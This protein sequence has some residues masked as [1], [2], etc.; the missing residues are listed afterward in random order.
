MEVQVTN[1]GGL[2]RQMTVR[3][4]AERVA[5]ALDERLKSLAG[6][7]RIAGFRPGKA[8]L[9][10]VQ[11]QYGESARLDVINDLVRGSYP[12]ALG[13]AGVHP[14]SAPSFEV[15]AEKAG[16]GLEYVARF[17]VYP[18]IKLNPLTGLKVTRPAVAVT[19]ADVEKLVDNLRRARRTFQ[20]VERAA[21]SGD[22]V[23][24]DFL[25]KLKGEPFEGG[26]GDGVEIEL[27]AKRFLPDL[28]N[29]I[30]GHK[31]GESFTV[32]VTFPDD[33][34]AEHLRGQTAQFDVTLKEVRETRLPELDAEFL[35]THGVEEGAGVD[36]L[37]AKC[38]SALDSER[39]KAVRGRLKAQ[40]M[41]QLLALNPIDV[42]PSVVAQEIGRLRNETAARFNAAK[43]GD[44]QKAKMFPDEVLAPMAQRR[45]ALGLLVAEVIKAKSIEPD[46]ARLEKQL[47][48]L[49]GD[50]EKPEQVKQFYRSRPDLMQGL[51]AMVLEEQ[52]TDALIADVNPEEQAMSLD[53]LLGPAKKGDE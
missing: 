4:P 6:R 50:Y 36:G 28:E 51:R 5:R 19:D 21:A 20:A 44:E 40:V 45:V 7:V 53:E 16:E 18:E 34:R 8:P 32:D 23:V 48:E 15:T 39:D 37:R 42:P 49:A 31:A 27:G 24:A 30:A 2:V 17:E 10:V 29:G 46:P 12:E 13:Q 43:L 3:I 25:G 47:D 38:R 22:Q 9:R 33:Y 41:E 52:V 1:P 11:Q 35:K 26:K 14:A